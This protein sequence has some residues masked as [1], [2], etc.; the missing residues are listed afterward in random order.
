MCAT[1]ACSDRTWVSPDPLRILVL[2]NYFRDGETPTESSAL[3]HSRTSEIFHKMVYCELC[4]IG[5]KGAMEFFA[6]S[7]STQIT[8]FL[9]CSATSI[10]IRVSSRSLGLRS[11]RLEIKSFARRHRRRKLLAILPWWFIRALA[12]QEYLPHMIMLQYAEERSK[13]Q[14]MSRPCP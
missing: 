6:R 5:E 1:S 12:L 14:M 7:I 13:I 2:M 9:L 8:I 4:K 3:S 11:K 10:E